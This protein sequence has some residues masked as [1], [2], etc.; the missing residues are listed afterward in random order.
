MISDTLSA[1]WDFSGGEGSEPPCPHGG[2]C[3]RRSVHRPGDRA[4][5]FAQPLRARCQRAADAVFCQYSD[6]LNS[7]ANALAASA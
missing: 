2:A 3:W 1:A 7:V 6:T 5:P 4:A